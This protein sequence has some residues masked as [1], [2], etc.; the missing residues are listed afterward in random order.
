MFTYWINAFSVSP[1]SHHLYHP[2]PLDTLITLWSPSLSWLSQCPITLKNTY[3][4]RPYLI[5]LWTELSKKEGLSSYFWLI[6]RHCICKIIKIMWSQEWFSISPENIYIV[7]GRKEW[8]LCQFTWIKTCSWFET[9]CLSLPGS[10]SSWPLL[11]VSNPKPL[12]LEVLD[13]TF[14]PPNPMRL[15]T[16]LL[17]FSDSQLPLSELKELP[18]G[19]GAPKAMLSEF[20]SSRYYPQNSSLPY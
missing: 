7:A 20:A 16:A 6:I 2:P 11:L 12:P 1:I 8:Y 18:R 15:T 13:S 5:E 3:F 17:G 14:C 19:K 9:R 4:I 10:A